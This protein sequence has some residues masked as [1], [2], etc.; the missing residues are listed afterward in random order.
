VYQHQT[1]TVHVSDTTVAVELDD[2]ETRVIQR[3]T[4]LAVRNIKADGPR[5]VRSQVV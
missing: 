3:T 2:G 4:T 5:P 1:V